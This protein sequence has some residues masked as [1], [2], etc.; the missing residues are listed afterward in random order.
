MIFDKGEGGFS[1]FLIFSD[2]WGRVGKPISDF[3]LTRGEGCLDPPFLDDIICE[4]S[5][6]SSI[7]YSF[8]YFSKN[9]QFNVCIFL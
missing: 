6:V 4:Q 2:K 9:L 7:F 5:L 8:C 1:Q 3:W